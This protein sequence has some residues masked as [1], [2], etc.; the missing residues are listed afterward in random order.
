[1]NIYIFLSQLQIPQLSS[2]SHWSYFHPKS[3]KR[4]LEATSNS[5]SYPMKTPLL[6]YHIIDVAHFS[7]TI[8]QLV[9]PLWLNACIICPSFVCSDISSCSFCVRENGG[10]HL[11]C[12][13]PSR[14][15]KPWGGDVWGQRR[16]L[17]QPSSLAMQQAGL[18]GGS[19]LCW[20]VEGAVSREE[21]WS[22]A[23]GSR[24]HRPTLPG[25]CELPASTTSPSAT[26]ALIN[27]HQRCMMSGLKTSHDIL[28]VC[29]LPTGSFLPVQ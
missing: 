8:L 18:E 7:K 27:S 19:H 11:G 25:H 12:Q 3:L 14:V 5:N 24:H 9:C 21:A 20:Q 1:M 6:S 28:T 2:V 17:P 13:W 29:G 16:R 23:D 4:I 22:P 10:A 15:I 26:C